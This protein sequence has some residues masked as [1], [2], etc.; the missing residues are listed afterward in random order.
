MGNPKVSIIIS[1]FGQLQYTKRCLA[2]LEETLAGK[3]DYEVLIIDHASKDGTVDFLKELGEGYRIFFNE[4]N[5]RF[6]KNN[7]LGAN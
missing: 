5:Q 3:L 2:Q 7:N 4:E 1:V 6:A